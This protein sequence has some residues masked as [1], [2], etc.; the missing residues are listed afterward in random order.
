MDG[1]RSSREAA[2]VS[3]QCARSASF[4]PGRGNPAEPGK[5][6]GRVPRRSRHRVPTGDSSGWPGPVQGSGWLCSRGRC[7]AGTSEVPIRKLRRAV[8]RFGKGKTQPCPPPPARVS[9]EA[10]RICARRRWLCAAPPFQAC[11][12]GA[13]GRAVAG[14]LRLG[15]APRPAKSR[16]PRRQ[17]TRMLARTRLPLSPK[18]HGVP[19]CTRV[20]GCTGLCSEARAFWGCCSS[21]C[22]S[23]LLPLHHNKK[24]KSTGVADFASGDEEI[25]YL[26][27]RLWRG[28]SWGAM[29]PFP[30]DPLRGALQGT[31][32]FLMNSVPESPGGCGGETPR[33]WDP[34]ALGTWAGS[35]RWATT[36]WQAQ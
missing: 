17:L 29:V 1:I 26:R 2:G 31:R 16:G 36:V 21:T 32:G 7:D 25:T 14:G 22:S 15:R 12:W 34:K 4:A 33:A 20:P 9:N 19:A 13:G 8:Q 3:L 18:A 23:L 6:V 11:C 27:R 24:V 10:H 5:G 35:A 30:S 28:T